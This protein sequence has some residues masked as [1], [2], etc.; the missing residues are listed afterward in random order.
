MRLKRTAVT[1][2]RYGLAGYKDRSRPDTASARG[3]LDRA[4]ATEPVACWMGGERRLLSV[5]CVGRPDRVDGGLR[6]FR[7]MTAERPT[8]VSVSKAAA[9]GSAASHNQIRVN[10]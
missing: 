8:A 2:D 10:G 4:I 6:R 7:P 1:Y 5:A 3:G 9:H